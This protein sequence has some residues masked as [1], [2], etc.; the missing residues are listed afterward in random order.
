MVPTMSNNLTVR[1]KMISLEKFPV[2]EHDVT[3]KKALDIMTKDHIGVACFVDASKHLVG[4][5]TDGDLRRL[6]LTKQ[7]PLPALLVSHALDFGNSNPTTVKATELLSSAREIMDSKRIWD[8]PVVD[9]SGELVGLLHR[10][11]VA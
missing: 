8:L 6:I 11:N 5:L 2:L 9:D 1:D 4:V 7:N 10:H 3:L